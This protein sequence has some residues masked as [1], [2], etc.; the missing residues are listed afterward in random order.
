MILQI[1]KLAVQLNSIYRDIVIAELGK[2]YDL[3]KI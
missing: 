2:F 3:L 1:D